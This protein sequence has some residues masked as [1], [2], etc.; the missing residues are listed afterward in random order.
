MFKKVLFIIMTLCLMFAP[1]SVSAYDFDENGLIVEPTYQAY[2]SVIDNGYTYNSV[3][4]KWFSNSYWDYYKVYR[5]TSKNGKYYLVDTV[6]SNDLLV[7]GLMTGKTYYFKVRGYNEYGY[8]ESLPISAT[9][10][11]DNI[12]TIY[13]NGNTLHWS[14]VDGAS[15]YA[16]YRQKS[17]GAYTRVSRTKLNAHTGK[18]GYTYKVRAYRKVKTN[19]VYSNYTRGIKL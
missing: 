6:N 1:V 7:D 18:K 12:A 17:N 11:L 8:F 2:V 19:Y 14:K 15:A 10:K 13:K 4:L 16:V 3:Y 9:P 5:A